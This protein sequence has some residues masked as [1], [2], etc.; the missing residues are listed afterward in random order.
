MSTFSSSEFSLGYRAELPSNSVCRVPFE[1]Q[2]RIRV[3]EKD[4]WHGHR[5]VLA[6]GNRMW[7]K[8]LTHRMLFISL[9]NLGM[10][11]G[12]FLIADIS[13]LKGV[14]CRYGLA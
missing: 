4:C 5:I 8:R 3:F 9:G 11:L 7:Q 13:D 14:H 2:I 10:A 6:T 1:W 12:A